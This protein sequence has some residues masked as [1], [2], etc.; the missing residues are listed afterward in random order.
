MVKKALLI[1][2]ILVMNVYSQKFDSR[3]FGAV[4]LPIGAELGFIGE[5][6]IPRIDMLKVFTKGSI[7]WAPVFGNNG[8]VNS[9]LIGGMQ[10]GLRLKLLN[11]IVLI[12]GGISINPVAPLPFEGLDFGLGTFLGLG[13]RI[14]NIELGLYTTSA[15]GRDIFIS[16]IG[17]LSFTI[18]RAFALSKGDQE[19]RN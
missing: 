10:P 6:E 14:K 4:S 13:F 11:E 1:G 12:S 2:A 7:L 3:F 5:S 18:S 17:W 9:V 16:D 19:L 15:I 8:P